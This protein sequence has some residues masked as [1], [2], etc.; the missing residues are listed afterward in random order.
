MAIVPFGGGTSVVG[1]L[2]PLRG[3]FA[4]LVSLDLARIDGVL[5][6]DERSL[7][8]T[9]GPGLR[10]PEADRL[11]ARYGLTLGHVPQSYEWATVG[12]CVATRSSGQTSTGLGGIA[13][14][15]V[16]ARLA[17]PAGE[18][19][20]RTQPASAAGPDLR[21]LVAGSEGNAG[22][23]HGRDA[24][25]ASGAVRAALRGLGGRGFEAGCEALRELEQ[26]GL[27]P[28]VARLS[29]EDETRTALA[30]AGANRLA[31]AAIHTRAAA[32]ASRGRGRAA[33]ACSYV[34]G[35]ATS[36][37]AVGGSQAAALGGRAEPRAAAGARVAGVAVRGAVRARRP[38]RPRRDGRDAGDGGA[39]VAAGRRARGGAG[40]LPGM[41][42][43]CHVSH[44][45]PRARRCTSPS[46]RPAMTATRPVSGGRRRPPPP[47]RCSPPAARSP[48]T[49]PW[50]VTTRRG[51]RPR[52][53]RW[54]SKRCGRQGAL[55]SGRDHEPGKAARR[56]VARTRAGW[57]PRRRAARLPRPRTAA[58]RPT[59]V[60]R[61]VA[62]AVRG[63]RPRP[64]RADQDREARVERGAAAERLAAE[65]C[66]ASSGSTRPGG[67]TA[68]ARGPPSA[69]SQP[70][71]R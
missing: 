27:A 38:A 53:A 23:D 57:R 14:N 16:G 1:G 37:A 65:E 48:T 28:D 66:A 32:L 58:A 22:G 25:G 59:R 6:V 21:Q 10:L 31:R 36:A 71:S 19:A 56:Y 12:G 68:L 63:Q 9:L 43:G 50:A 60:E 17:T 20:A 55:R 67:S 2:E 39:V 8:A 30:F 69:R 18:L 42:V 51:W 3:D 13:A 49:T 70:R 35:T 24:A 41:L 45:Y 33:R 15:L 26:A 5:A 4:A 11:L 54:V 44:L 46:S 62:T 47:T 52:S 34:A 29:D 7:T 61:H 40:A 64:A